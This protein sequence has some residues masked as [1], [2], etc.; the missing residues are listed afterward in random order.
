[1]ENQDVTVKLKRIYHLYDQSFWY[2]FILPFFICLIIGKISSIA[3][4][5]GVLPSFLVAAWIVLWFFYPKEFL[6]KKNWIEYQ[7]RVTISYYEIFRRARGVPVKATYTI[8]LVKKIELCQN[9]VEKKFGVGHI[10]VFG[11]T[12]VQA[13]RGLEVYVKIPEPHVIRG[14]PNFEEFC[15]QA[16]ELLG[17]TVEIV[18]NIE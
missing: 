10:R 13:K 9:S 3:F 17:E 4:L 12:E 2:Y 1:M 14:I 8:W 15:R 11:S 18:S 16:P 6:I 7:R 5:T